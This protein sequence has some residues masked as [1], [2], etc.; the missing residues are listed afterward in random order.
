[1]YESPIYHQLLPHTVR[2]TRLHR[3]SAERNKLFVAALDDLYLRQCTTATADFILNRLNRPVHNP[4][5]THLYLTNIEAD[6][7]NAQEL[8]LMEGPRVEF[9]A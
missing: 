4:L 3:Q 2:L 7:P 6:A 9:V 8:H 5:L 1:M